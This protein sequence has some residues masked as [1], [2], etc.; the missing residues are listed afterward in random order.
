MASIPF[1]RLPV[2]SQWGKGAVGQ[3]GLTFDMS[4]IEVNGHELALPAD[5]K[6][7]Q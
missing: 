6:S 7:M 5:G 2:S 3:R 4:A 1:R